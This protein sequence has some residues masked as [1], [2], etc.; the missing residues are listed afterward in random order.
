M[1]HKVKIPSG[2]K[3]KAWVGVW[4]DNSLGWYGVGHIY[5]GATACVDRRMRENPISRG[6]RAFLCDVTIT[7]RMDKRGNPITRI[8]K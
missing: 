7:P 8:V 4:R 6:K 2:T 3:A 5:K 1:K